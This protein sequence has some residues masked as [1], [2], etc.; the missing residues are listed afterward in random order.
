MLTLNKHSL[1]SKIRFPHQ[2]KPVVREVKCESQEREGGLEK[3][4]RGTL[5]RARLEKPVYIMSIE[6][7]SF[8]PS[9]Y[10]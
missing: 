4:C 7:A 5:T 3:G 2:R 9:E 8:I 10:R 6:G 1:Y